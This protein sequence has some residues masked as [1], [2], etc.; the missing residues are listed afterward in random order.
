MVIIVMTS[1]ADEGVVMWLDGSGLEKD[2]ATIPAHSV[3]TAFGLGSWVATDESDDKR[4]RVPYNI[5]HDGVSLEVIVTD[6]SKKMGTIAELI[7][8][9]SAQCATA[10]FAYLDVKRS[11][12]DKTKEVIHGSFEVSPKRRVSFRPEKTQGGR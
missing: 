1:D 11:I 2:T 10:R 9:Y 5:E 12:D 8:D 3:I 6:R 4:L 7:E